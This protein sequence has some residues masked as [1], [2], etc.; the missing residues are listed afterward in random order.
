MP[1]DAVSPGSR[2]ALV[3]AF[4][5]TDRRTR[6]LID[7]LD[8][9]QR[10]V[11]YHRG[12]NPPIW[13]LGHA[14]FFTEYF[15]L[16]TVA[17]PDPRMPGTDEIWDSF[18]IPHEVRWR[19]GEVPPA[20]Q[21]WRYYERVTDETLRILREEDLDERQRYL[22]RYSMFHQNMHIE[23][24]IW[25]RQ[26]LGY[27]PPHSAAGIVVPDE[28]GPAGDVAIP[29]GAYRFG[30][31]ADAVEFAGKD[32]GFDNEKPGHVAHVDPFSISRTLVTNGEFREFVENGGYETR[33]L[34]SYAGWC[35]REGEN[36]THPIY[37]RRNDDGAWERRWFDRWEILPEN[38]PVVHVN[39]YEA[40]AFARWAGRRLPTE[41]EWEAAARGADGRL[42]AWGDAMD[43][44]RVDMDGTLLGRA[45]ADALVA[46][47]TPDGCLQMIGTC[48]EW[49]TDQFLPY[50]G[51]S[52]DMYPYMSTLQFGDHRVTK[53][54]S[55]ATSSCLIRAS[56][57]QAYFPTRRDVFVG[58]RTCAV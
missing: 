8:E 55:A 12:I 50:D 33:D 31:R 49:T 4:E 35:W 7:Q 47:A 15:F 54:G 27:A 57:R 6:E 16:R 9:S 34:W 52:V 41:R 44:S 17:S 48:W 21:A 13:E 26:T 30:M 38:S 14:A 29:G 42:Y 19:D 20:E 28:R 18:Q 1:S 39:V 51:F 40:E 24:L 46:G 5:T 25:C 11:P 58:F 22:A 32:F 36:A 45:P 23:S 3:R 43:A 53:G 10:S 56:Y 37:W 2:E